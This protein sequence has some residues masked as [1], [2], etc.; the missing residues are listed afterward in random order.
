[1]KNRNKII[2]NIHGVK[3][4]SDD[5]IFQETKPKEYIT[6]KREKFY[7]NKMCG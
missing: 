6:G 4:S 1:V 3:E 2:G 7:T 5:V